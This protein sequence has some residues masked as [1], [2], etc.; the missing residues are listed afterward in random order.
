MEH[1]L[2]N[3]INPLFWVGV[4]LLFQLKHNLL[5]LGT[6]RISH[7]IFWGIH[8]W[9]IRWDR[10]SKSIRI[11]WWVI[12]WDRYSI[13]SPVRVWIDSSW[14]FLIYWIHF[15]IINLTY[16]CF[17][18]WRIKLGEIMMTIFRKIGN[19]KLKGIHQRFSTILQFCWSNIWI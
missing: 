4:K 19:H 1:S 5:L 11:I 3:L 12:R 6:I 13:F 7:R 10:N 8:W 17:D 15:C 18:G 2:D 9:V 14:C 16:Y